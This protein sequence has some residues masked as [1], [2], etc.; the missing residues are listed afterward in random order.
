[1]G[2]DRVTGLVISV[3]A[4]V[5]PV[6]ILI[7]LILPLDRLEPEP[8][9]VLFF[10]FVWGAGV[11]VVVSLLL[12]AWGMR[13]LAEPLFG[14]ETGGVV[15]TSVVAPMVEERAKGAV[16]LILLWR[17][18]YEIDTFTDGVVY[19]GM[20]ALGFAFTEN[21]WAVRGAFFDGPLVVTVA[22]RRPVAPLGPPLYPAMLGIGVAH[23]AR[24][25]GRF[26]LLA[27]VVG[28]CAAVLLHGLWN[29]PAYVGWGGLA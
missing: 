10:A 15:T 13:S 1:A 20:V 4:A 26:R 21:S 23:A 12:N 27:P 19:G 9:S 11:A 28:W 24:S 8:R 22:L 7:P 25:T 16:L 5:V 2:I 17:R 14:A 18:R 6:T 3:V 29:T